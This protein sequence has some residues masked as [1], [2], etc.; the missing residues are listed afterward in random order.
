MHTVQGEQGKNYHIPDA[1]CVV[2]VADFGCG[3]GL[4]FLPFI[5]YIR[6]NDG[7]AVRSELFG[8]KHFALRPSFPIVSPAIWPKDL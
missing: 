7:H 1:R 5:L 4:H 3:A 8:N 2:V 6:T